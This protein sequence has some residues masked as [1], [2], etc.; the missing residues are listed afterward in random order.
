MKEANLVA[1][2]M[3]SLNSVSNVPCTVKCRLGV[4]DF[5]SYEF[6][7]NFIETVSVKGKVNH[8]VVHARKAILKVKFLFELLLIIFSNYKLEFYYNSIKF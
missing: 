1:E 3:S 8:F 2:I 5:D 6:L 7:K 4:D